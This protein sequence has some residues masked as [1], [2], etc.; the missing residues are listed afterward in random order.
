MHLRAVLEESLQIAP[1]VDPLDDIFDPILLRA[2]ESR[3]AKGAEAARRLI[4]ALSVE[5]G[6][7]AFLGKTQVFAGASGRIEPK[8]LAIWLIRRAKV[9][10]S[11]KAIEDL[12]RYLDSSSLPCEVRKVIA[13]L[14]VTAEYDLGFGM[15]LVP[16]DAAY[17]SRTKREMLSIMRLNHLPL[18][19]LLIKRIELPVRDVEEDESAAARTEH[20]QALPESAMNDIV[21]CLSLQGPNT[22]H[23][24]AEWVEPPEWAPVLVA[25][26]YSMPISDAQS[27]YRKRISSED[28]SDTRACYK[29]WEPIS[30][31]R[32]KRLRLVGRWL[33]GA[34]RRIEAVDKAIGLGVSLESLFLGELQNDRGE[35]L[36]RLRVRIARL[37]ESDPEKRKELSKLVKNLYFLRSQ[38]VHA[39]ELLEVTSG[40]ER[41]DDIFMK[42]YALVGR[43]LRKFIAEGEPSWDDITFS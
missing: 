12:S 27:F 42:G 33:N 31:K 38:A 25:G 4:E 7:R 5:P 28:A 9:V 35:L 15:Q 17:D 1:P 18:A 41:V 19:A 29:L 6:L 24:F 10:G 14:E 30:E 2:I 11:E 16:W 40:G 3:S 21:L 8:R 39:G 37:M 43:A 13:G 23:I 22:A 20:M 36:F 32:K 34:M 26:G